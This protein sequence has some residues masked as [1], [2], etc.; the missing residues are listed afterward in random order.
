M[1]TLGFV[2]D[3]LMEKI[4]DCFEGLYDDAS[5]TDWQ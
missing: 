1:K 3:D 2:G 4:V 5:F